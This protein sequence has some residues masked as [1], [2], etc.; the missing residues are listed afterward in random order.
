MKEEVI[1]QREI[2]K[3]GG[4]YAKYPSAYIIKKL[5]SHIKA[6]KVLDVTYGVGRFYKLYRPYLL[7]AADVRAWNWIVTP[8]IFILK[9]VWGVK[10]VLDKLRLLGFNIT[11]DCL[12][13][14]P[15]YGKEYHSRDWYSYLVGSPELIINSAFK[16]AEELDIPYVLLHYNK[17][18]EPKGWKP[19]YTIKLIYVARY[20]NN[21]DLRPSPYILYRREG[22]A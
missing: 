11:F 19:I 7:I 4:V 16:L 13:V 8:D 22:N 10:E 15:P 6:E 2:Q 17:P 18:P 5:L 1:D 21:P 14:D 3:L 12:V 20:L 9:P